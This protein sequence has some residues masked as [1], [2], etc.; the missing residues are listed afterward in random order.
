VFVQG[1]DPEVFLLLE[2]H[3]SRSA[4]EWRYALTRMDSVQF[5]ARYQDQEIWRVGI[6]PWGQVSDRR[7]PY[8]TFRHD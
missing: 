5:V 4:A 2:A 1:T 3:R 6:L 8:T 7:E